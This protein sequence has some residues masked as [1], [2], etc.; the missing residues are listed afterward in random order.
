MTRYKALGLLLAGLALLWFY[1]PQR[2]VQSPD[3]LE[4]VHV[5]Y[6]SDEQNL[7]EEQQQ[8]LA[9]ILAGLRYRRTWLPWAPNS[10]LLEEQPWELTFH[11]DNQ[12]WCVLLGKENYAHTHGNWSRRN[13]IGG[14]ELQQQLEELIKQG[15]SD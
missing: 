2:L 4:F 10:F 12:Y 14:R 5:W 15:E 1:M 8:E 9:D 3:T 7:S 13:I 11:T 6:M